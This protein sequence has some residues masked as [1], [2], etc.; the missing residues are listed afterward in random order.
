MERRRRIE[1]KK[2]REQRLADKTTRFTGSFR[3]VYVHIVIYGSWII[4]NLPQVPVP[5]FDP[6]CV[7][8]AMAASVEAIFLT[9]FVL[10]TQNRMSEQQDK[11]AELD[12]QISLLAEH[13]VTR[14]IRLVEAIADK[15]Q[16]E[17]SND[18]ELSGTP[19]PHL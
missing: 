19:H 7:V 5:K 13:E 2:S 1:Q 14:L 12:L 6:T 4:V 15:L 10:M 9:T 3:F 8:L 16:V 18:P 11:R 17:A